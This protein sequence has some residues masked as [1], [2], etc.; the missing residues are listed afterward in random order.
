MPVAVALENVNGE[1]GARLGVRVTADGSSLA[2]PLRFFLIFA[3]VSFSFPSL[4]FSSTPTFTRYYFK[5]H[6]TTFLSASCIY[7]T[8]PTSRPP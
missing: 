2:R 8:T 7:A 4:T 5:K 1:E 3:S 6:P